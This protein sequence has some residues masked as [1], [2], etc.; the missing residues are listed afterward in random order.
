MDC[1][2]HSHRPLAVP[3][4]R[5]TVPTGSLELVDAARMLTA[6]LRTPAGRLQP[7][8]VRRPLQALDR[9]PV[10]GVW[11]VTRSPALFWALEAG[12]SRCKTLSAYAHTSFR[13]RPISLEKHYLF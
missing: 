12:Y 9:P 4:P 7:P 3:G 11:R 8:R 13:C 2:V 10:P 1:T 6:R 5:S